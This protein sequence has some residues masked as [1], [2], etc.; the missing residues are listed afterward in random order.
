MLGI[1][2]PAISCSIGGESLDRASLIERLE[3]DG[4]QVTWP[5]EGTSVRSMCLRRDELV[6]AI[7]VEEFGSVS[8]REASPREDLA[9]LDSSLTVVFWESGRVKVSA[10]IRYDEDE[11]LETTLTEILGSPHARVEAQFPDTGDET[12]PCEPT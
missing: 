9:T 7:D 8:D 5:I 4:Y 1:T 2:I 11:P 12:G 10:S 3:S 6:D